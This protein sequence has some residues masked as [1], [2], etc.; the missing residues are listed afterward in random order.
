MLMYKDVTLAQT[1]LYRLGDEDPSHCMESS[2]PKRDEPHIPGTKLTSKESR[3]KGGQV[4][5]G[6]KC[7]Y[8]LPKRGSEAKDTREP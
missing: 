7:Y 6:A 4:V 8:C 1:E 3:R 5:S 2:F